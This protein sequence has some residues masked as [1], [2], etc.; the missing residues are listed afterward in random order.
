MMQSE[1]HKR[2]E[3]LS[4]K[5]VQNGAL[6]VSEVEKIVSSPQLYHQIRQRIEARQQL[7]TT[8]KGTSSFESLIQILNKKRQMLVPYYLSP[9]TATLSLALVG[10]F[11]LIVWQSFS[12]NS[13][14]DTT[15]FNNHQRAQINNFPDSDNQLSTEQSQSLT[16][17][18]ASKTENSVLHKNRKTPHSFKTDFVRARKS[19]NRASPD[20]NFNAQQVKSLES[21]KEPVNS[22]PGKFY[23][24]AFAND[25]ESIENKQIVR[26]ELSPVALANLGAWAPANAEQ[27]LQ[28]NSVTAD[29]LLGEDGTPRAIRFVN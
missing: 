13:I 27:N 10:A 15:T 12:S 21:K 29:L 9:T 2:I 11:I 3:E 28:R 23:P 18:A 1:K 19:I 7:T 8:V 14:K 24:L 16:V 4:Q 5:L 20:K 26:V 6:P 25:L 17:E 22:Q